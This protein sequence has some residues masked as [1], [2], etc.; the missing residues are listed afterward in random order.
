M[1]AC[2][3]LYLITTL[4][5]K[6]FSSIGGGVGKSSR[7]RASAASSHTSENFHLTIIEHQYTSPDAPVKAP[8]DEIPERFLNGC[9]GDIREARRRWDITRKWREENVRSIG[10][11]ID[12]LHFIFS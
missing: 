12:V 11:G 7:A 8:E 5:Y 1:C 6:M 4:L 3:H 2:R 9:D 10:R